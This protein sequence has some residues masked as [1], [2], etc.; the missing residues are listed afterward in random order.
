[1]SGRVAATALLLVVA[2][3]APLARA[4]V[5]AC[6]RYELPELASGLGHERARQRMGGEGIRNTILMPDAAETS[7]VD[8]PGPP[9]DVYVQY[10]HRLE[11]SHAKAVLVRTSVSLAPG[12]VQS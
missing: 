7:G 9:A 12:M 4:A 2:P 11:K 8:Y 3:F 10:D 5:P 6:E 1:M